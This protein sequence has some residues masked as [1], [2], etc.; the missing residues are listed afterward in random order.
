M[1]YQ[2]NHHLSFLSTASDKSS[3]AAHVE[4]EVPE[5]EIEHGSDDDGATGAENHGLDEE[6]SRG[7]TCCNRNEDEETKHD[8]FHFW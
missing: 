7:I 3:L 2:E 6:G 8:I 4:V 1:R 5:D